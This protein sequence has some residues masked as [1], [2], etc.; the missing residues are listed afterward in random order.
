MVRDGRVRA[1]EKAGN[2]LADRAAD[3]VRRRFTAG[4]IDAARLCNAACR[5]WYPLVFDL[6]RFFTAIARVV[7][8]EDGV[9]CRL[10]K[11]LLGYRVLLV[12][13]LAVLVFPL[14]LLTLLQGLSLLVSWLSCVLFLGSLHWPAV[15][16]DL[17]LAGVSNVEMLILHERFCQGAA[18]LGAGSSHVKEGWTSKFG[19]GCS[20][21]SKHRYLAFL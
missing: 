21:S 20:G 14:V 6:H 16:D 11:S 9:C 12:F 1:L 13:R 8:N 7:F 17:G 15:V 18:S 4:I 2:D 3:L 10:L 5:E 19:V